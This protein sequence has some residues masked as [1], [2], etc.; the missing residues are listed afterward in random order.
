MKKILILLMLLCSLFVYATDDYITNNPRT[1]IVNPADGDILSWNSTGKYFD[2]GSDIYMIDST[3]AVDSTG[4]G[5]MS[6]LTA[7]EIIDVGEVFYMK[8]DGEIYLA[9]ADALVTMQVLGIAVG[10][11]T[12]GV[13]CDIMT[14][15]YFRND[16]WNWTPGATLYAS[17]TAGGI[18]NTA[19]VGDNDVVQVLGIAMSADVI[20]FDPER[21]VIELS[22]P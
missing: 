21:T 11:G 20:Y 7:G 15:G 14:C 3:P 5:T 19:P 8:S 2:V 13:A 12:N 6:I 17:V 22:V 4:S 18:S 16:A 9:D 10:S 1:W